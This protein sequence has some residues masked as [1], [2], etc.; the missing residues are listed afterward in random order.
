[1]RQTQN[2]TTTRPLALNATGVCDFGPDKL[3]P[4]HYVTPSGWCDACGDVT[5]AVISTST[6]ILVLVLVI[7]ACSSKRCVPPRSL[8]GGFAAVGARLRCCAKCRAGRTRQN[9]DDEPS[10]SCGQRMKTKLKL[11]LG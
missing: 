10:R 6:A 4:T 2:E 7:C 11:I 1:M 9:S 3:G 5:A 8:R